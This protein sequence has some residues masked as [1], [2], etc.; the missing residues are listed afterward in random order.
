MS[1][2]HHVL[3]L[4]PEEGTKGLVIVATHVSNPFLI[5]ALKCPLNI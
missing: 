2:L 4:M 1:Y 5:L 3:Q